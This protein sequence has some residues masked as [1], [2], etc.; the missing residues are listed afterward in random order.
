MA[1]PLKIPTKPRR[2]TGRT[3]VENSPHRPVI[4]ELLAR[5]VPYRQVAKRFGFS[6][7]Q[8][9]RHRQKLPPAVLARLAASQYRPTE[10]DL[11]KLKAEESQGLLLHIAHL[12]S[13]LLAA[14]DGAEDREDARAI[15]SLAGQL[16]QNL[17][18]TGKYL[19]AFTQHVVNTQVSLVLSPEY[20]TLRRELV[21]I[22][23]PFPEVAKLVAAELHRLEAVPAPRP[24]IEHNPTEPVESEAHRETTA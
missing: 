6:T 15:A 17:E 24:A 9:M 19:S 16:H 11:E 21:Q 20:L 2:M 8:I 7:H 23:R 4:E 18:L 1:A 14:L 12:R 10:Q 13:R 3:A 22:L 5:G